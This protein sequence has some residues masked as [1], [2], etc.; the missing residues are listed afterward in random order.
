VDDAPAATSAVPAAAAVEVEATAAWWREKV[1][2]D[3]YLAR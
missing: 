2:R 3:L 1:E